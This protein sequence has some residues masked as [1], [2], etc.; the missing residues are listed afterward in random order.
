MRAFKYVCLCVARTLCGHVCV[1]EV[2][3]CGHAVTLLR[4]GI[5]MCG[6]KV[7]INGNDK[8]IECTLNEISGED[9]SSQ[10]SRGNGKRYGKKRSGRWRMTMNEKLV[11]RRLMRSQIKRRVA[12]THTHT[13]EKGLFFGLCFHAR[14]RIEAKSL[15]MLRICKFSNTLEDAS[16]NAYK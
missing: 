4:L 3:L 6:M 1:C 10:K 15:S 16:K 8:C 5:E 7:I 13:H 11:S 9:E 12:H 2:C 14:N